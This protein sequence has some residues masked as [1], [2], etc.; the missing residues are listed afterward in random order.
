MVCLLF[1][2]LIRPRYFKKETGEFV[3]NSERKDFSIGRSF[4]TT[5]RTT[6]V[7]TAVLAPP[8]L[9]YLAVAVPYFWNNQPISGLIGLAKND[10]SSLLLDLCVAAL[11]VV[12][13]LAV[14]GIFLKKK[15]TLIRKDFIAGFEDSD[16]V[17]ARINPDIIYQ[18]LSRRSDESIDK[19]QVVWAPD[20]RCTNGTIY[21]DVDEAGVLHFDAD[22]FLNG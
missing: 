4:A 16:L 1:C 11:P 8:T 9:L 12:G 7:F 2:L 6:L 14:Y 21:E 10:A 20:G 3:E 13:L 19:M 5:T 22:R 15:K 18:I 17:R